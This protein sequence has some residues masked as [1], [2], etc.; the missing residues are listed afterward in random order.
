M[1]IRSAISEAG[2]LA[3]GA[4]AAVSLYYF[5]LVLMFR[6][7]S[8]R[9]VVTRYEPPAGISPSTAAYLCQDGEC[10]RAFAAGIISLAARRYLRV[11]ASGEQFRIIKI[12][13]ADSAIPADETALLSA[14]FPKHNANC[15]FGGTDPGSLEQALNRFREVM[16]A[17]A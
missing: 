3:W 12:R 15:A 13:D 7:H 1:I 5:I 4:L 11:Y 6:W 10:E 8:E 14:L 16:S 2:L 17:I 9:A